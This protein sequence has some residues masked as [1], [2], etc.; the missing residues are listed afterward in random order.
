MKYYLLITPSDVFV[1]SE[2]TWKRDGS[3]AFRGS[4]RWQPIEAFDIE[5]AHG[6]GMTMRNDAILQ[7]MGATRLAPASHPYVDI[8][9]DNWRFR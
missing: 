1:K 9:R 3:E 8:G 6:I 2:E 7:R 4:Y 5:T